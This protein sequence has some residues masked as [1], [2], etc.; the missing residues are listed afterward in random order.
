MAAASATAVPPPRPRASSPPP[1]CSGSACANAALRALERHAILRPPRPRQARLDRR[2]DRA[3][4]SRC[5]SGPAS[6][7][8]R[9]SPCAFAYASTSATLRRVAAGQPQVVERHLVDREDRDRRAVLRAHVAERHAVGD[10]QVRRGPGRRTR[11]TCR[12]RRACAARSVIVS[13]RSVAVVALGQRA[14]SAGTPSTGGISIEIGWPSIAAS[15][16]MPPTP[17]PTTPSP[18]TIVVCESVPTS[19]SGYATAPSAPLVAARRR[20]RGTRCSPGGRCRC[21]AA[22]RGSCGTRSG[23]SAGTRSAPGCA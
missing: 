16:S 10:R 9:N 5:R 4:S 7:S 20:A 22:R 1:S 3:R 11:R 18:L 8:S 19:V 13:T 17:Q 12:R 23:P 2:R 15:A 6:P 14:R 21:R